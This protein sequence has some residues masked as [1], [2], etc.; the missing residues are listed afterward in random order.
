A[1]DGIRGFHVTGVQTC[2]LQICGDLARGRRRGALARRAL[3]DGGDRVL[4]R[5]ELRGILFGRAPRGGLPGGGE[6][7]IL[8]LER[9]G[10]REL[11]VGRASWREGVGTRAGGGG[12]G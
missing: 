10:G 5:L 2:A 3:R 1:E 11:E 9:V 4:L 7:G 6:L 8:G 12:A